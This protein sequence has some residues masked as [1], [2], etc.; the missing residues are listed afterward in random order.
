MEFDPVIAAI[1]AV[2][3]GLFSYIYYLHSQKK[4]PLPELSSL[5]VLYEVDLFTGP[6]SE[7]L[8]YIALKKAELVK[9][10]VSEDSKSV[11]D[12]DAEGKKE[13]YGSLLKRAIAAMERGQKINEELKNVHALQRGNLLS[14]AQLEEIQEGIRVVEREHKDIIEEANILRHRGGDEIFKTAFNLSIGLQQRK[15][16][17]RLEEEKI[18]EGATEEDSHSSQPPPTVEVKGGKTKADLRREE[19]EKARQTRAAEVAYKKL[20]EEEGRREKSSGSKKGA[21]K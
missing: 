12:V 16:A 21:K 13:L 18:R 5:A 1:I 17:R 20:M 14:P 2:I 11:S 8:S 9:V 15:D 10:G 6:L 4:A 19:E 7:K 3:V